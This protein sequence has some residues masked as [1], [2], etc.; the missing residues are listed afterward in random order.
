MI[1]CDKDKIIS[2]GTEW[3]T[4][5]FALVNV[6]GFDNGISSVHGKILPE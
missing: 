6:Y 5:L 3:R 2:N 4:T 1:R